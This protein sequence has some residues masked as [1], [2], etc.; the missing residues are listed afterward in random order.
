MLFYW[1]TLSRIIL[2]LPISLFFYI[3][4]QKRKFDSLVNQK[5]QLNE[6]SQTPRLLF[7]Y[8]IL[9][10]HFFVFVVYIL[11]TPIHIFANIHPVIPLPYQL[12]QLLLLLLQPLPLPIPFIKTSF[13]KSVAT[14]EWSLRQCL[15]YCFV[16][17]VLS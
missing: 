12:H 4:V 8:F 14:F 10:L 9:T 3:L 5:Q 1:K 2:P 6:F 13:Y 15:S 11:T 17:M 7:V 16:K